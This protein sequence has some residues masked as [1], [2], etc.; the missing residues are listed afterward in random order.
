MRQGMTKLPFAQ[1]EER[2]INRDFLIKREEYIKRRIEVSEDSLVGRAI[3]SMIH[4]KN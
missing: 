4:S 1:F 2:M 3:R